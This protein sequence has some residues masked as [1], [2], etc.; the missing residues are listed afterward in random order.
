[1]TYKCIVRWHFLK[2]SKLRVYNLWSMCIS[3][4]RLHFVTLEWY[5]QSSWIILNIHFIYFHSKIYWTDT[6]GR[7]IRRSNYDGSVEDTFID[8]QMKFPEGLA[9]DWVSRNL[10]WTDSGKGTIE[11]INLDSRVR[12]ILFDVFLGNPRE[13]AVLPTMGWVYDPKKIFFINT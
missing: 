2:T 8:R 13:I 10:F 11:V 6:T 12:R 4:L 1:M 3:S 9:I 7:A 5:Q